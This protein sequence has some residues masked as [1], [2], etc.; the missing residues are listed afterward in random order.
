MTLVNLPTGGS[1]RVLSISVLCQ[2]K[3][4]MALDPA[5]WTRNRSLDKQLS[6]AQAHPEVLA[7]G[8]QLQT[9]LPPFL[10]RNVHGA[11]IHLLHP[12]TSPPSSHT[13]SFFPPSPPKHQ[14][15]P[16]A[17]LADFKTYF[18]PPCHHITLTLVSHFYLSSSKLILSLQHARSYLLRK[19][20]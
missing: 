15:S 11:S 4:T 16:T 13:T 8:I 2:A 17:L 1:G 3:I 7:A 12:S 5:G 18:S 19:T 14:P 6:A 20:F 10:K 9:A